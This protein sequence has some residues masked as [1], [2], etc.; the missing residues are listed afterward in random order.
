MAGPRRERPEER[1]RFQAWL[2]EEIVA[3][4]D[5]PE[6][7]RALGPRRRLEQLLGREEAEE[8]A[9]VGQAQV[10]AGRDGQR[11]MLAVRKRS[12]KPRP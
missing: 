9:A 3:D 6:V 5:P 10:E 8:N 11:A 4:A 2:L 12:R 1:D 7:S